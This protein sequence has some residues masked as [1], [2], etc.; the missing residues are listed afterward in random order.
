[1]LYVEMKFERPS[2]IQTISLPMIRPPYK[3]LI[4]STQ[5]RVDPKLIASSSA[6]ICPT[7]ELAIQF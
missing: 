6:Q 4:A 3:H 5:C 2:K 1:G 7:R